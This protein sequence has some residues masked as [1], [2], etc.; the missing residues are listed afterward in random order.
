VVV[1]APEDGAMS[2]DV[3]IIVLVAGNMPDRPACRKAVL[4]SL[5][6]TRIIFATV[7]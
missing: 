4:V 6:E 2:W 3:G 7:V 1:E 5:A